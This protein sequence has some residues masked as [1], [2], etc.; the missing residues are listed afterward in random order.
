MLLSTF[1]GHLR[2]TTPSSDRRVDERHEQGP[3][4][5]TDHLSGLYGAVIVRLAEQFTNCDCRFGR[6][7]GG[8]AVLCAVMIPVLI[9]LGTLT[10]DQAYYG[11]RAL[12]LK[13][14]TQNAALAAAEKLYTYYS[15]GSNSTV[16]STAQTY[17]LLNMPSAKYGTVVTASNVVSEPGTAQR[18]QPVGQIRPPLR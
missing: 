16:V 14:T 3:V 12:L 15:T 11:Y 1:L 18:S 17:A 8:M 2:C 4:N 6:D 5:V 13:Q 10:I 9:G 7:R